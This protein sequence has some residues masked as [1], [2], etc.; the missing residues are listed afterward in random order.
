MYPSHRSVVLLRGL[1]IAAFFS[2]PLACGDANLTTSRFEDGPT[3]AQGDSQLDSPD[4]AIDALEGSDDVA[5]QGQFLDPCERDADCLS[6]FCIQVGDEN[7]CSEFCNETSCPEGWSCRLIE[8][9]GADL[10]RICV[11]N[12]TTL[13]SPCENN[14]DCG[15]LGATCIMVGSRRVCGRACEDDD[16]C[17][18]DF[19]CSTR[20]DPAGNQ[21]QQCV[22]LT[23]QCSC[24]PEV[25]GH[26]R[27]CV[28]QSQFGVCQGL[29]VCLGQDGWS[30][31]TAH[32]PRA[33]VCDG[34]DNNCDGS[35]DEHLT[36]RPCT[37]L[38]N[39]IGVCQGTERCMGTSG[40]VCDAR[41]ASVE[42]CDGL[43]ND[44]NGVVDDGL[45]FDGNPCTFDVCDPETGGCS[46]PPRAGACDD[47]DACTTNT[48]CVNGTCQGTPVTCNDNN[49]CTADSCDRVLG[50][51][52]TPITGGGC[53]TG[54]FCTADYCQSGACVT[55]P[56]ES[57][58]TSTTCRQVGCNPATGCTTTP[59]TGNPCSNG[60]PCT[61]N[62]VC[63]NGNC[64]DGQNYCAGR[65]CDNCQGD[66]L[67]LGGI[68]I[69]FF[70]APTCWCFC[71]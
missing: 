30:A 24:R 19:F 68:C 49:P 17:P 38:P 57:C 34:L 59:L 62:D 44:C 40:W 63:S 15:G 45:C 9:S 43:D 52:H 21:A 48:I 69:E 27:A 12:P 20:L 7:L 22:P 3:D 42:I 50:C 61:V 60:D 47:G 16:G 6:N 37:S 33:E 54:N 1:A 4:F 23:E 67:T 36:P 14:A 71:V 13:C 5:Q 64:I 66:F 31:C 32:E 46:Y 51:V 39:E 70:G 65:S 53:Q 28:R 25:D 26:E 35:I 11:P 41:Q 55:G 18:A 58:G 56:A 29:E 10:A 8:N 2:V